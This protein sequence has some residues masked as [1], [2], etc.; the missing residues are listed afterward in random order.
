MTV[1]M[2]LP[3]EFGSGGDQGAGRAVP[4]AIPRLQTPTSDEPDYDH[5]HDDYQNNVIRLPPI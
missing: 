5:N 1:P 4:G 3:W 2:G